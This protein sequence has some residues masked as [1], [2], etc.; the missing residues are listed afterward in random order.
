M[1]RLLSVALFTACAV[2]VASLSLDPAAAQDP[3][4]KDKEK[5]KPPA[6]PARIAVSEPKE[7]ADDKDFAIQ[8][9]YEGA[10]VLN[11]GEKKIGVQVVAKGAG[12][13]AVKVL[14][15]GLPGA[16]ADPKA[17]PMTAE[18]K[19]GDGDSAEIT[20]K[21][22][23]GSIGGGKLT[24]KDGMKIDSTLTKVARTSPTV[25]AKPPEGAEV[26]FTKAGDE[27]NW[28]GGKLVSLS[29]GKFLNTGIKTKKAFG[30]F[31]AHVEFRLPW[32]PNSSGQGR[33]NSG[34][35][36]QDRYEIQVL[37]SFGLKGENNECGGI[38]TLHKPSVNMCLPP[39]AWQTY[40]IEF[41]AAKFDGDTKTYPATLTLTHNGVKIHDKVELK[42][43]TGGGQPESAKPG[44]IQLQN[45]GDPLVFRNIWVVETK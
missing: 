29:D 33:G 43:P 17:E 36:V 42:G 10:M 37:D 1:T 19:R 3:K 12:K 13:F 23:S 4:T 6:K 9:E 39:M 2:G 7:L 25:G 32:M 27:A 26:L 5:A 28:T 30:S 44:P 34:F 15:G 40:D 16:G 35:Y 11:S 18:A 20:G 41:T 22:L 45:H 31:T 14:I 21:T 24:L 8:G 38:Y